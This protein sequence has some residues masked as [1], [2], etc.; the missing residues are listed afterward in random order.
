MHASLTSIGLVSGFANWP[1]GVQ[2]E[3]GGESVPGH[4]SYEYTEDPSLQK[5]TAYIAWRTG[6]PHKGTP[7]C[8]SAFQPTFT[9]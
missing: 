4:D 3:A 7:V 2:E 5:E 1:G 6:T 8:R 9:N